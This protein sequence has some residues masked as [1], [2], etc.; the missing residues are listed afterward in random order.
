MGER[1]DVV[2]NRARIVAAAEAVFREHGAAVPLDRV[3]ERAGVGRGTLY[4]HF[5]DRA[6]LI[7]AVYAVR[8]DALEAYAAGLPP[9]R[10]LEHL[11]V[12]IAALQADAPGLFTAVRAAHGTT[13]GVAE[14]ER[15]ATALLEVALAEAHRRGRVREGVT[16]DDVRLVFAMVEGV[17]AVEDPARARASVRR[18]LAVA[19]QGLLSGPPDALPEPRLV[20]PG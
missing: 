2:R 14:V 1:R 6:A 19:L 20:L 13:P 9:D 8:V 10:L 7:A 15:R 12:E 18:A 3:A 11:V 4:R 16:V 17:L 5:P